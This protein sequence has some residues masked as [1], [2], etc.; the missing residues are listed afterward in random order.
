MTCRLARYRGR[1][2]P[3][4]YNTA[5]PLSSR[6]T[7][8]DPAPRETEEEWRD[9]ED[10]S[11]AMLVQGVSTRALFRNPV[12]IRF[13]RLSILQSHSSSVAAFASFAVNGWIFAPLWNATG[14]HESSSLRH[15][16]APNRRD[17]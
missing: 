4:R 17:R 12:V 14:S 2:D 15:N 13:V 16:P 6:P 3:C 8:R 7:P 10:I 1:I 5:N 11:S 9:P